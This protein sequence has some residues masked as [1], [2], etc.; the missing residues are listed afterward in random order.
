M[1]EIEEHV[2]IRFL[3]RIADM[4]KDDCWEW[5]GL[6]TAKGYGLFKTDRKTWR[7]HRFSF[8]LFNGPFNEK[9]WVLHGCDNPSCVNPK[10]LHLGTVVDNNKDT[11]TKNRQAKGQKI[12]TSIFDEVDIIII[13]GEY[14]CGMSMGKLA[15]MFSCDR[16]TIRNIVLRK[17]WKHVR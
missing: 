4:P 8:K 13:R 17:T 12:A 7:A 9:L 15:K 2:R 16:E 11:V 1:P 3:S 5:I 14:R 6:K 10:H